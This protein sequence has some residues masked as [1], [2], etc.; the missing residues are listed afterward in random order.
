AT[1]QLTVAAAPPS[2]TPPSVDFTLPT[3]DL[4]VAEG[5]SQAV[6][7]DVSDDGEI[8]YCD[9][10]VNGQLQRRGT[11]APFQ[12]N[13]FIK[14]LAPGNYALRAECADAEGLV[15]T[16]TRQLTVL[17]SGQNERIS[18]S[19][20]SA[21]TMPSGA[22]LFAEVV[23]DDS[24]FAISNCKLYHNGD[25]VR[26]ENYAPYTW[27][28]SDGSLDL[29]LRTLSTGSHNLLADCTSTTGETAQISRTLEV[30]ASATE[31]TAK[32]VALDWLAPT[33]REDGS[34][35]AATEIAAYV[36][37]YYPSGNS[38]AYEN[39]QVDAWDTAGNMISSKLISSLVSG[40]WTF[41]IASVDTQ[42]QVSQFATPVSLTIP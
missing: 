39:V 31:P 33:T 35:L 29:S 38:S 7:L 26:Q 4:T 42:G 34:L 12:Y 13:R 22:D 10:L 40:N 9:L 18:F 25:F 23:S 6:A 30:V 28:A 36:I 14:W 3:S 16:A 17:A 21:T 19:S 24:S 5:E 32:D 20:P 27:G 15:G 11:V 2:N 37:H 41:T 8:A 1:R